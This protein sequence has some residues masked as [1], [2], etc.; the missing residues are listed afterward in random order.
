LYPYAIQ[1]L[2]L[3]NPERGLALPVPGPWLLLLSVVHHLLPS[4][5]Q[6]P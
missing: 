3:T 2:A 5:G 1:L 6:V 4:A